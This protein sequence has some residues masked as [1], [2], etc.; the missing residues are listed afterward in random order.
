LAL[1]N[2]HSLTHSLTHSG[3]SIKLKTFTI[4]IYVFELKMQRV[5]VTFELLVIWYCFNDMNSHCNNG[6][7]RLPKMLVDNIINIVNNV[8]SMIVYLFV[9]FIFRFT[10]IYL[11]HM[12]DYIFCLWVNIYVVQI[13]NKD[14]CIWNEAIS[15]DVIFPLINKDIFKKQINLYSCSHFRSGLNWF[16]K[17]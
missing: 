12:T 16:R 10:D 11:Y 9:L 3:L 5:V 8:W 15:I 7:I 2:T 4:Q 14:V 6:I 17:C 13:W 1:S